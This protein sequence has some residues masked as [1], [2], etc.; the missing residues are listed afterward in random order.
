MVD[1]RVYTQATG[2]EAAAVETVTL[3]RTDQAYLLQEFYEAVTQG[4]TAVTTCH[5]NIKSLGIV[6]DV[7]QS[8]ETA[9]VVRSAV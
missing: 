1:D 2:Q 7:V 3:E 9:A 4:K 5:D 8:F 6:F